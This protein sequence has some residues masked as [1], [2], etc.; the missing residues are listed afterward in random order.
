MRAPRIRRPEPAAVIVVYLL[1]SRQPRAMPHSLPFGAKTVRTYG[2]RWR[3]TGLYLFLGVG[4]PCLHFLRLSKAKSNAGDTHQRI[5]VVVS[6]DLFR[7]YAFHNVLHRLSSSNMGC[8]LALFCT[9]YP[10]SA[11]WPCEESGI[12]RIARYFFL[13]C[14]N[15][16]GAKTV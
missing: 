6:L 8:H 4:A 1:L 13:H 3:C 14:D 5:Q 9:D 11:T 2:S 7:G 15:E 10:H 12:R 16:G